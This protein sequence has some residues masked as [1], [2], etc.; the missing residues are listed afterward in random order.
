MKNEITWKDQTINILEYDC[1]S[2]E[3]LPYLW[4][5]IDPH[6]KY[7]F[8]KYSEVSELICSIAKLFPDSTSE[9]E[10]NWTVEDTINTQKD[11]DDEMPVEKQGQ[12]LTN[13]TSNSNTRIK[14]ECYKNSRQR[15]LVYLGCMKELVSGFSINCSTAVTKVMRKGH[16]ME[17]P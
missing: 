13:H 12:V 4:K 7:E 6:K 15:I 14:F 16:P 10:D 3:N 1:I 5:P 8:H 11:E 2:W 9:V 17:N